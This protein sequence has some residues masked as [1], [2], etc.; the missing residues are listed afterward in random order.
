MTDTNGLYGVES[1]TVNDSCAQEFNEND[2]TNSQQQKAVVKT[3]QSSIPDYL[4]DTYYWSYLNPRNV[5]WLDKEPIVKAILWGQHNKLR[6][7]AF[8]NIKPGS[9]VLQVA[10][11]Y[12]R[13]S[14]MLAEHI[15]EHGELKVIDVAEV[16][17]KHTKTK[18][19]P[20]SFAQVIQQDAVSLKDKAYDTVMCYFLLHEV[21]DAYKTRIL[22]SM[23]K[24]IKP[25]GQLVIID[26]HKPHWAHPIRPI[27]S[28][29][30]KF[31]EPFAKVLWHKSIKSFDT[32]A[33]SFN[34]QQQTYFGGLFQKVVV[35]HKNKEQ[36]K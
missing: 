33:E 2:Y 9:S 8:E 16:Q 4:N 11:V 32:N 20:Y 6:Q 23:L 21:P 12:G 14:N 10:A 36:S 31:L 15:G 7:A 1:L 28:M 30:F 13:F 19:L 17:V 3:K 29:V 34:W 18:L 22:D 5:N 25:S 26:Y 24:H 35:T 27:T